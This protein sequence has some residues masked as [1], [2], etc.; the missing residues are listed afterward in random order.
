MYPSSAVPPSIFS[1]PGV[2]GMSPT[3]GS[4][5]FENRIELL[6]GFFRAANH[7]AVAAIESPDAAAGADIHVVNAF[8]L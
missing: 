4:Q 6:H 7:H 1:R 2:R 8:V 3:P 5:C